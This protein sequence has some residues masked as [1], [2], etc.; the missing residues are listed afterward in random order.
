M[1]KDNLQCFTKV[2]VETFYEYIISLMRKIS[3]SLTPTIARISVKFERHLKMYVEAIYTGSIYIAQMYAYISIAEIRKVFKLPAIDY[4]N[5]P[6]Y[7]VG[8]SLTLL[9]YLKR[10]CVMYINFLLSVC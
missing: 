1:R 8:L 4:I 9:I 6:L 5:N 7:S 3:N 2:V 10:V